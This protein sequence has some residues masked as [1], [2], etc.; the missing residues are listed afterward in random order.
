MYKREDGTMIWVKFKGGWGYE[1]NCGSFKIHNLKHV[2][3]SWEKGWRLFQGDE[4]QVY[5]TL[6][7]AKAAAIDWATPNYPL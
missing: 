6:K 1:S 3:E 4:S 7:A 5:P 2:G